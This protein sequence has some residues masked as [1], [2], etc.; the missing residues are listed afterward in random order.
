[1]IFIITLNL[2]RV[3]FYVNSDLEKLKKI[4]SCHP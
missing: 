1:L 4:G 2:K 3:V